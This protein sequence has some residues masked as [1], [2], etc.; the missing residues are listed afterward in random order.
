MNLAR[1]VAHAVFQPRRFNDRR[2]REFAR[3]V[4]NERILEL[5]SGKPVNG[6]YVYS[7]RR[8]FDASNE[9]IQSDVVEEYG[10]R[11]I[12]ATSMSFHDEFDVVLC[13]NVLEH[14]YEYATVISNIHT[15]LRPGGKA[16]VVVPCMYPLHDQP[17]DYWRFT[18]HALRPMLAAFQEIRVRHSGLRAYPFMYYVEARK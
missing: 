16:V 13:A 3:S 2:I 7:A 15:A 10:H 1:L 8:F 9:F 5:G 12:D 6:E 4:R 17:R 11:V 18:E 14:V